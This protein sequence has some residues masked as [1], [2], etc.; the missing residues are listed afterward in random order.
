MWDSN[1]QGPTGDRYICPLFGVLWE[2]MKAVFPLHHDWKA[3]VAR[4]VLF[5]SSKWT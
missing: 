2:N 3:G 4:E 1:A 5:F